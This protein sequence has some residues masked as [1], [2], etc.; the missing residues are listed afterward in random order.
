MYLLIN[1]AP[2]VSRCLETEKYEWQKDQKAEE[3]VLQV[4]NSI[5]PEN[6]MGNIFKITANWMVS[7]T[8]TSE[9][10]VWLEAQVECTKKV[11]GLQNIAEGYLHSMVSN[12]IIMNYH[13]YIY[14]L[15][16]KRFQNL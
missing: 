13:N 14:L 16:K 11:W 6:G 3:T 7:P 9:C 4:Y 5:T 10:K 12:S 15:Y 1:L 8:S 2:E